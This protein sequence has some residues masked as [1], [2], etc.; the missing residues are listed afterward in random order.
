MLGENVEIA[1]AFEDTGVDQLV[2]GL[3]TRALARL[4]PYQ[5][6]VG[7]SAL[8]VF[9]EV[10]A[11]GMGGCGVEVEIVLLDVLAMIALAVSQAE[12]DAP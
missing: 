5:I 12:G 2:F 10:F 4:I 11:V 1:V 9:V 6:V 8:R 7:E 3:L